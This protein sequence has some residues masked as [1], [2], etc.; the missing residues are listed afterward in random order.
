MADRAVDDTLGRFTPISLEALDER[1]ALLRR[2]DTKYVL[3][4]EQLLRFLERLTTDH[5]ALEIDRRRRF[6][7]RSMYFDT[8]DLR[9]FHD[10]VAG[11]RPRFKLRTRCYL[12]SGGCQLEVKV[13]TADD[14]THKRQEE[15]A[16]DDAERLDADALRRIDEVLD[17][18]GVE[19][20]DD[21]RPVLATE[22]DRLTLA[23][24]D[25]GTRITCDLD[26][27]LV[28]ADGGG[29]VRLRDACAVLE[30]K[31]EDGDSP[32]DRALERE[33]IAPVSM[34]KYRTGIDLLVERDPTNETAPLRDLFA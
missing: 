23:A 9:T 30:T 13:K 32:A 22:F 17:D 7:Y 4:R 6:G 21:L 16:P 20:V 24:R 3:S 8:P 2:V 5:D 28:R 19:P 31:S 15:H 27:R 1:A 10:H 14:E 34:S 26:L 25:G 33:G 29:S 18:A 11:R 12:D